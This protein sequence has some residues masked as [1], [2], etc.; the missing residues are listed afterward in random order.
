MFQSLLCSDTLGRIICEKT[1]EEVNQL[2]RSIRKQFFEAYSLFLR[3]VKLILAHVSGSTFEEI[4]KGL[5]RCSEHLID[6]MYLIKLTLSVE[7]RVLGHHFEEDAAV[8]PD[9]HLGVVVAI[10]HEALGCSV[11]TCRD[12]LRVGLFGVY[13][14]MALGLPLHEPKSASLME[15]PEMRTFS[16]LMS[17]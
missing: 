13:A 11:P 10:S 2:L 16:G 12:V 9:V 5:F 1:V 3:E 7:E 15:S 14:C 6:L 4:D 8:T 17:R